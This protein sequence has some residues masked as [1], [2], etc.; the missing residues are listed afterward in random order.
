MFGRINLSDIDIKDSNNI[1]S[2]NIVI[3]GKH[4]K[5]ECDKDIDKGLLINII[6]VLAYAN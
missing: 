1:S 6:G 2:S 5:V 3:T 4:V